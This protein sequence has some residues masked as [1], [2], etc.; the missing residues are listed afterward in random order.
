[1]LSS[2]RWTPA[3]ADVLLVDCAGW[4]SARSGLILWYHDVPK[5][6]PVWARGGL[7]CPL[8]SSIFY[9]LWP[10]IIW[11]KGGLLLCSYNCLVHFSFL[12]LCI[13]PVPLMLAMLWGGASRWRFCLGR[14]LFFLYPPRSYVLGLVVAYGLGLSFCLPWMR[15]WWYGWVRLAQC[16]MLLGLLVGC[17]FLLA[18]SGCGKFGCCALQIL[19][20]WARICRRLWISTCSKIALAYI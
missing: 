19:K 10:W 9:S 17:I 18:T 16:V 4:S 12:C 20:V 1:M 6:L 11:W 3:L 5:I 2:G 15:V 14:L 7:G 8:L 13:L